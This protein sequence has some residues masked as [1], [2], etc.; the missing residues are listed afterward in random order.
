[1]RKRLRSF[2]SKRAIMTVTLLA[3]A[4]KVARGLER[5]RRDGLSVRRD[6]RSVLAFTRQLRGQAEAR[7]EIGRR[8]G[9][10][11]LDPRAFEA[12]DLQR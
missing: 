5:R 6:W 4:G 9:G 11:L 2:L 7:E 10:D 3:G 8:E 12:E 1:L